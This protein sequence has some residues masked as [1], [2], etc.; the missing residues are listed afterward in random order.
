MTEQDNTLTHEQPFYVNVTHNKL[1][2]VYIIYEACFLL[3]IYCFF[4]K[5]KL[6]QTMN[7][8]ST[9]GISMEIMIPQLI[10]LS[11]A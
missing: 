9:K 4:I 8:S 2:V 3:H 6:W 5:I 10:L 11:K 7:R 1:S